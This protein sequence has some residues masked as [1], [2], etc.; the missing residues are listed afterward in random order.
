MFVQKNETKVSKGSVPASDIYTHLNVFEQ[1]ELFVREKKTKHFLRWPLQ[2]T[3]NS[4]II[5]KEE[6]KSEQYFMDN[7][8]DQRIKCAIV[9]NDLSMK[10]HIGSIINNIPMEIAFFLSLDF[11]FFESIK[12]KL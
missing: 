12:T 8:N 6:Q 11:R 3:F 9:W 7:K 1:P 2:R 5:K 4:N 10:Y